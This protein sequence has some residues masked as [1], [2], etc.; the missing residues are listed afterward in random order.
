[1]EGTW[2]TQLQMLQHHEVQDLAWAVFSPPLLEN[3]PELPQLM[4]PDDEKILW[5][6]L[7]QLDQ[8]PA[9]LQAHLTRQPRR[10]GLYFEALW[11]FLLLEAPLCNQNPTLLAHNFPVYQQLAKGRKTVGAF[12]FILQ[13]GAH[14]LPL[15]ITVKFYLGVPARESFAGDWQ[16]WPGPDSR[17]SAAGKFQHLA[18]HQLQLANSEIGK[19]LLQQTFPELSPAPARCII[20]GYFFYPAAGEINPPQYAHPGHL[21]GQWW[22]AEHFLRAAPESRFVF[23]PKAHWLAPAIAAENDTKNKADLWQGLVAAGQHR[24]PVMLAEMQRSGDR[25]HE[26]KR[27]CIVPDYWPGTATPSLNK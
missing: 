21:R 13:S 8:A 12:D 18:Q 14:Y 27:H 6:W 4:V 16:A 23:L 17:D 10:L 22:Y 3:L 2:L 9:A 24:F 11:Q 19:A 5:Q 7:T 1:M 25:W 20:K 26:C 15:E